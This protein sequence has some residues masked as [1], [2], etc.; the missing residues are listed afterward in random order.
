MNALNNHNDQELIALL[1]RGSPLAFKT[2]FDKYSQKLYRF[3]LQYLKSDTDSEE[4][5]QE[6]FLKLWQNREQIKSDTS[7]KSYLFTIAF[8]A[9]LK[10]FNQK[11]KTEKYRQDIFESLAEQAPSLETHLNYEALL[12]KLEKLIEQMPERRREIFLKRKKEGKSVKEIA[13]EM[14][15][16]SKTVENQITEAMN[17][18]RKSFGEDK[19]SGPLFLFLFFS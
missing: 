10:Q 13:E 6:V 14:N 4:I 19:I 3:S 16:S 12:D 2:L 9:I 1:R 15:I 8:N 11:N 7:F 17:F 5:V 18:L